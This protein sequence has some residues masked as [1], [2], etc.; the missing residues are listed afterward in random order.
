M[1]KIVAWRPLDNTV[2][3]VAVER[4]GGRDRETGEIIK[5]WCAYIRAVPG[6]NHEREAESVKDWGNK[7]PENIARVLFPTRFRGVPYAW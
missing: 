2:L 4:I 5:L 1:S 6:H 7:L 3:A